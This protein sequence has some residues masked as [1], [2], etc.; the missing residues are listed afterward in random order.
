MIQFYRLKRIV[1]RT[2][3]LQ[4]IY[5]KLKYCL[6]IV[7]FYLVEEG[8]DAEVAEVIRPTLEKDQFVVKVLRAEEI[9]S[10]SKYHEIVNSTEPMDTESIADRINN[11]W[12]CIGIQQGHMIV[13]YMWAGLH[14]CDDQLLKFKLQSNEAYLTYAYTLKPYRGKKIAPF[15]RIEL[16]KY[17]DAI[18][19]NRFYSITEYVNEP[20]IRFKKKLKAKILVFYL[21]V[22]I[23]R[24][25][26]LRIPLK[27]YN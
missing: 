3:I 12:I 16:Y 4:N 23:L 15:L 9:H 10:I 22:C 1:N 18:G 14:E 20:A 17:L 19:R 8:L 7:P 11:G 13:A 27:R 25:F 5:Q 24:K 2:S 26:K 21:Y 6:H